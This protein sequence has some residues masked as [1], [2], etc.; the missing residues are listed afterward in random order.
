M[1]EFRKLFYAFGLAALLTG[2]SSSAFAQTGSATCASTGGVVPVIRSESYADLVGDYLLDCTGGI[3]TASGAAVPQVNFTLTLSTHVTSKLLQGGAF[4][5]ALLFIDEPNKVPGGNPGALVP[6]NTSNGICSLTGVADPS[7]TYVGRTNVFQGRPGPSQNV[8]DSN[9]V[10]FNGV[11]FDPPGTTDLGVARHRY[12]R[13]NNIRVDAPLLSSQFLLADIVMQVSVNANTA[14]TINNPTQIVARVMRGLQPVAVT[15]ALSTYVQCQGSGGTDTL[16][17]FSE[18][19]ASSFKVRNVGV[20][21]PANLAVNAQQNIAGQIYNTESGFTNDGAGAGNWSSTNLA[22]AG[23]ATQGTRLYVSFR[24]IPNGVTVIVPTTAFLY[25][26]GTSVTNTGTAVLVSTQAN[27][28][29]VATASP[30]SPTAATS[31]TIGTSLLAVYEVTSNDPL[32]IEDLRIPVTVSYTSNTASNLPEP[33]KT[34]AVSGGFAPWYDDSVAVHTAQLEG[35]SGVSTTTRLPVPRF[36]NLPSPFADLFRI[37]KCSCNL[38]FPFVTNAAAPGGNYDT[39]IAIANTS[40]LPSGSTVSGFKTTVGQEGAVQFWYYPA[41]STSAPVTSQCTNTTSPGTCPG[42][43]TV[44]AG[45][46]LTYI[47]SQGSSTWGLDGRAAGFTGYVVAQTQF[48]YCHAFAYISPQGALPT[49][50]GMSVG[51]LGLVLDKNQLDTRTTYSGEA[52]NQ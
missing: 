33:F 41:L 29:D 8:G 25:P 13:F 15:A 16:V 39:G 22:T 7:Q 24:D 51:Y 38:L 28:A 45:E 40:V 23:Q 32:Q 17:K 9:I 46:T 35:N 4:N 44:K 30:A 11:P 19:F 20:N 49:T 43:K 42:T 50:N 12:L 14:L 47:L 21:A 27:G 36:R 31:G 10:V 18:G 34:T 2:A 1:A 37:N 3:P 5:E 26:T 6:C 52:L 48:Q